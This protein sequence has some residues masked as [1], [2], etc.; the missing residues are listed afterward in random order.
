MLFVQLESEYYIFPF[1]LYLDI[2]KAQLFTALL[3]FNVL[4]FLWSLKV[5]T[6]L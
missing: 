4:Q 1:E 5:S 6:L 2:K 3:Q